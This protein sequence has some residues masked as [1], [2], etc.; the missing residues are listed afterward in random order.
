MKKVLVGV[1]G[2]LSALYL[3]N[4]GFGVFEFIPDNIPFLGNLDEG[5]AAT[6][7]LSALAFFGIDL[8]EIFGKQQKDKK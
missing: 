3:V 2:G 6:L 8:K 7:L 4:P 1:I 5:V